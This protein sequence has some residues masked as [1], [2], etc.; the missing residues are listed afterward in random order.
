MKQT[1]CD[2]MNKAHKYRP[3]ATKV[4]GMCIIILYG[5]RCRGA[6]EWCCVLVHNTN[7][8]F[9]WIWNHVLPASSGISLNACSLGATVGVEAFGLFSLAAAS[10]IQVT[11]DKLL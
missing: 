9:C 4:I 1:K 6:N 5:K 7:W 3:N 10:A 8:C 2:K 11:I